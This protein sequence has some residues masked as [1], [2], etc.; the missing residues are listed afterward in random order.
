MFGKI[1]TLAA[2]FAATQAVKLASHADTRAVQDRIDI[3]K[4][5]FDLFDTDNDD[6]LSTE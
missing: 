2:S 3:S 4:V 6:F 1:F 5:V